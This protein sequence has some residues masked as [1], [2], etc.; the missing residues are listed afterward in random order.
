MT[1][2]SLA[3]VLA[4]LGVVKT[5][6]RPDVSDDNP[7]SEAHFK[8]IKYRPEYPD[9]FGSI[10]DA[11][12]FCQEFF[13]LAAKFKWTPHRL[14]SPEDAFKAVVELAK[15]A[16]DRSFGCRGMFQLCLGLALWCGAPYCMV[17]RSSALRLTSPIGDLLSREAHERDHVRRDAVAH[18]AL[19][20]GHRSAS[21]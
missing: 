15:R 4:D 19:C 17:A 9:C 3:L 5:R 14:S 16:D 12:S 13:P 10:Q 21:W 8:T 20:S 2:K 11:R 1:S 18:N 7:F 6:S